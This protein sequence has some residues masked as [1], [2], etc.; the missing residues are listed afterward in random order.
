MRTSSDRCV[1]QIVQILERRLSEI[2]KE[3]LREQAEKDFHTTLEKLW[4]L[5]SNE[6]PS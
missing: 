4:L 5:T 2:Q 3:K 6:K 1:E